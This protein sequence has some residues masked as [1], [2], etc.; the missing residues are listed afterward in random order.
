MC[1]Q[2][3]PGKE[4][5]TQ[6]VTVSYKSNTLCLECFISVFC[7]VCFVCFV[8]FFLREG[9]AKQQSQSMNHGVSHLKL[10]HHWSLVSSNELSG[11][12]AL[13]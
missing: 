1:P 9:R 3:S 11:S 2:P 5:R 12:H 6:D 13:N 10:F 4:E 8:L 7:F